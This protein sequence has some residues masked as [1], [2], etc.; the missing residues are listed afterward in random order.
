MCTRSVQWDSSACQPNRTVYRRQR[1]KQQQQQQGTY[2]GRGQL[3]LRV[4]DGPNQDKDMSPPR[5]V[6][7]RSCGIGHGVCW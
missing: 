7:G 2:S 4:N 5:N 1:R 3:R 6:T